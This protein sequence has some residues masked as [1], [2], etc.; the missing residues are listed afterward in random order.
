MKMYLI[1]KYK[2]FLPI[3]SDTPLISMGE[4]FTP[5][6]KS[7]NIVKDIGCKELYFKLE[8][9]NPSGSFKDRGMVMAVSKALEKKAKKIICAST[10]NTSA[11]AA[12]FGAYCGL[13]TI[14][15]IPEGKISL[16]KLSQAVAYG[17]KIIS[18]RGNFDQALNLV[19]EIAGKED[20]IELVNSLNPNRIHGQKTG[21][22]EIVDELGYSPDYMVLPVGNAGNITAYWEGYKIYHDL[23]NI[24]LPKMT[25]FQAMNSAPIVNNAPVKNP[26]TIA[27]A[28]RIGNPAS[29]NQARNALQES[30]G[31]IN[32]IEDDRI[33]EAYKHIA[34]MEGIFV[35]PASSITIAGL[36]HMK[37]KNY[38]FSGQSVVCV[39]TGSGL[40]DPGFA[41]TYLELEQQTIDPDINALEEILLV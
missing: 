30:N 31:S 2:N 20:S 34:S 15:L 37:N 32:A 27:T 1:E 18:V 38:D 7:R 12:A 17:A 9:C 41:E 36:Y 5:L 10:G 25:G 3:N 8:G 11:S 29:W 24:E 22:F 39:L 28:I 4:G 16:G 21:A 14:V 33:I 13:E 35:E 26:Q 19:K 23:K 40:K 6:V